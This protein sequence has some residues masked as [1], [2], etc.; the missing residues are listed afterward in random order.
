MLLALALPVFVLADLPLLG[1][2]V[3]AVAWLFQRG[4]QIATTRAAKRATDPR[5]L[6]GITAASM[7]GR[8]WLVAFA[9][10]GAGLAGES[11]DGLAAAVLVLALFTL[12]FTASAILRPFD[13]PPRAAG[14][15]GMDAPPPG[16]EPTQ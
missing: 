5:T 14:R 8:G 4:V 16:K 2:A 15:S 7:I 6:V 12:Y 10:F 3:G 9:V 13:M 11:E 1:Y